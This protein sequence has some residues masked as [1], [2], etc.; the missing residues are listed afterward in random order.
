MPRIAYLDK[1]FK[2][3]TLDTIAKADEIATEYQRQGYELT[4]RQLY[5]QFVARGLI[6]NSDKSYNRLG[7]IVSEARLTGLLDWYH[8]TD[9]TR[10]LRRWPGDD[11]PG[12]TIINAA[13]SYE[14]DLWSVTNQPYRPEVWVEK[15]A[16]VDVVARACGPYRVPHFSCRGYVSQS[17]MWRAGQRLRLYYQAGLTPVVIHLGDHDPSGLDMT[18]DITDRLALFTG[19]PVEVRRVA[20]N[21]DQVEQYSPPPNPAKVT[22]ARAARYIDQ[23]GHESWELDALEPSVLDRL[24]RD[25]VTPYINQDDWREGVR[26]DLRDRELMIEM[27]SRWDDISYRWNE[28]EAMLG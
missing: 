6:P 7:V 19:Q 11:D 27:A 23:Y 14:R 28:I 2:Q 24:I 1:V 22:D 4:L 16:L 13:Q 3:S 21:L 15:D 25:E 5:Y 18:R 12:S 8:I 26:Q 17:E 20:L 10:Y 9:R